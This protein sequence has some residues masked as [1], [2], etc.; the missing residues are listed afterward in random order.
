[1]LIPTSYLCREKQLEQLKVDREAAF[2]ARE[3]GMNAQY[4]AR[5]EDLDKRTQVTRA[6]KPKNGLP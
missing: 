5:N 6:I 2:A 1:M 4:A 3:Q